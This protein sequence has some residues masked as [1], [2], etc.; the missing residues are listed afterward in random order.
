MISLLGVG[1]LVAPMGCGRKEPP[2]L[3][4]KEFPLR[5]SNLAGAWVSTAFYL[6]GTI[7]P[8]EEVKNGQEPVEGCRVYYR[9]YPRQNPPCEGCPIE[10]PSYY[11]FGPEVIIGDG[12]L[13][14]VPGVMR[15]RINY[16]QVH[17]IGPDGVLGPPSNRVKVVVE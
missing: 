9:R 2:F 13:C 10:F 5:V 6:K 1:L 12:F 15:G 17:L 7:G 16:F 4:Q 8:P 11:E 14:R 3:H